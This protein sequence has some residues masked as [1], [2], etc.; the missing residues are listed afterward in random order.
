MQALYP[1]AVT[2]PDFSE[3]VIFRT[4]YLRNEIGDSPIFLDFWHK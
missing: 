2:K 1:Y 3:F 4:S